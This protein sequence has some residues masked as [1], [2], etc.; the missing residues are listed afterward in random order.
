ME[1]VLLNCF[2]NN[3]SKTKTLSDQT[4]QLLSFQFLQDRIGI[5]LPGSLLDQSV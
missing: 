2:M 5:Y 3:S 4:T 1:Y